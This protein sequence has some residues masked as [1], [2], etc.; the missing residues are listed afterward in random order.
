MVIQL[1]SNYAHT[2][3]Y[4][5]GHACEWVWMDGGWMNADGQIY[6]DMGA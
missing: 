2:G 4:V 6:V 1:H 5:D 3:E